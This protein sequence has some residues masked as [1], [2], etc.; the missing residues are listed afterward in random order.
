[1]VPV[2]IFTQTC[3]RVNVGSGD[4]LTTFGGGIRK[5]MSESGF[6]LLPSFALME[7]GS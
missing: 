5:A 1:M 7:S 3:S 6:D 4:F 2:E